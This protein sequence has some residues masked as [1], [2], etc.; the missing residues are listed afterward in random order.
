MSN[1]WII[2]SMQHPPLKENKE[3]LGSE[4]KI[5]IW[6]VIFSDDDQDGGVR[7]L[8]SM[9]EKTSVVTSSTSLKLRGLTPNTQYVIYLNTIQVKNSNGIKA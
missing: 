6:P 2:K 9:K 7:T 5:L 4:E 8:K 3:L 1:A